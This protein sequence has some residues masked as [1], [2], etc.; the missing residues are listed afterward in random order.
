MNLNQISTY[1]FIC[2]VLVIFAGL[3]MYFSHEKHYSA[4]WSQFSGYVIDD[5]E[6]SGFFSCSGSQGMSFTDVGN[7]NISNEYRLRK[8]KIREPIYVEFV[9]RIA[10]IGGSGWGMA[11]EPWEK[12][13]EIKSIS[14]I[15]RT[16]PTNCKSRVPFEITV[17]FDENS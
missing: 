12:N 14:K 1:F 7:A 17:E 11:G 9:G 16:F 4:Q 2:V 13:I 8:T 3:G 10:G 6:L 15:E 5:E